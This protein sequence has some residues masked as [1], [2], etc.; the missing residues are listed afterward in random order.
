MGAF[1]RTVATLAFC[2]GCAGAS[3][4]TR[5]DTPVQIAMEEHRIPAGDAGIELYLRNKHPQGMA[6]FAPARV[7]LFVHGATYP[8]STTFDLAVGGVSWMDYIAQHGFDVWLV[9]LRGYGQSTRPAEMSEPA[10]KNPPIVR[11]DTAVRDVSSAIEFIARKRGIERLDLM[12]WSWGT[13]IMG[14]YAAQHPERVERLVLYA[15]LWVLSSPLLISGMGAYRTVSIESTRDR[16]LKG[17]AEDK[18]KDLIP[19]GYFEQWAA[20]T[21]ASDPEGSKKS[22]KVLRAPNGVLADLKEFWSA[23]KPMYDPSQIRAPTLLVHAEWDQDLPMAV[24]RGLFDKLT[25]AQWKRFVEIGEGT[26]TVMLEK[27]R[28]Q[29]FREVELFL[30]ES[31]G[32]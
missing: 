9:D 25:G 11:T 29:L 10:D 13:G 23:G 22:P 24:A 5:P 1:K 3:S 16:W 21:F 27:N 31:S 20:T 32:Q 18:R 17:V 30:E 15:P 28:M 26:H 8:A 6:Q 19:A 12:G 14:A 4:V 7:L 2:W